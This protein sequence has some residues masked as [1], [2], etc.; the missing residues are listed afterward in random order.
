MTQPLLVIDPDRDFAALKALASPV[1]VHILRLLH[2]AE[3]VNVNDIAGQLGVPQSSVSSHVKI[4]EEAGLIETETRKARKGSQKLCRP[5]FDEI[6]VSFKR[7][8]SA[9]D[10]SD[11]TV[12]MPLGLY[13]KCE[14]TAPCG[15]CS[16]E[17]II[18]LLDVPDTFLEPERM[19]SSLLWFTSGYV[20]YQFPNN[21]KLKGLEVTQLDVSMEVCS[22]VPG[23]SGEWPSDITVIVNGV[24]LGD[25][26]S[27][28]DY[29]DTRGRYTPKWWKLTGSQ[30]GMLK[31]WTVT[32]R[33]TFVDGV[34]I[35][36]VCIKDLDVNAHRSIRLKVSVRKDA[37]NP[38]GINIFG[39]G[40]GNYDQDIVMKL[41]TK[42]AKDGGQ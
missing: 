9:L 32:E 22:E 12:S 18:G 33:G 27:P 29:G 42:P 4:L 1:R 2:A 28:G 36:D 7:S 41:Q 30:Y 31:T 6:I 10:P 34:K 23:T 25:W 37:R 39:R 26:T 15:I 21:A 14:V 35:S 16:P 24:P 19:R 38:G 20:E 13:T 17:G 8:P 5:V 11:I 40:F 3:E